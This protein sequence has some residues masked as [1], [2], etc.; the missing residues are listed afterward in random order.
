MSALHVLYIEAGSGSG[1]SSASL[2]R[3]AKV[4]QHHGVTPTVAVR[5]TGPNVEKLRELGVSIF[6]IP[7]FFGR[8]KLFIIP[9]LFAEILFLTALC[10]K[11]KVEI[12]H[13][14]TGV[15]SGLS[16][17]AAAKCLGIPLVSH[18]RGNETMFM[19]NLSRWASRW[20][21]EYLCVSNAVRNVYRLDS[22]KGSRS[23]KTLYDGIDLREFEMNPSVRSDERQKLAL[24]EG[25]CAV[26][27]IA[28]FVE[29]KGHD[30]FL[31]AAQKVL[32][33]EKNV[34]FFL[35]GANGKGAY[36]ERI[37]NL[38][39]TLSLGGK[40]R[41]IPWQSDVK[42]VMAAMD[43]V[44]LPSLGEGLGLAIAEAMALGKAVI[45]TEVGGIPEL[46]RNGQDGILIPPSDPSALAEAMKEL[47][48]NHE[49]RKKMSESGRERILR[50]FSMA[51]V[52]GEALETYERLRL[53]AKGKLLAQVKRRL[54]RTLLERAADVAW[55]GTRAVPWRL[56]RE[57]AFSI[58]MYHRV[59][60]EEVP[61]FT[62]ISVT[63]FERQLAFLKRHFTVLPLGEVV[64]TLSRGKR[65]PRRTVSL[66]FDDGIRN[67]FSVA[68]PALSAMKLPATVFLTTGA[69]D[70]QRPLWT[71]CVTSLVSR[72][73]GETLTLGGNG[74]ERRF[75]TKTVWEKITT[76][77]AL[78]EWL[79]RL[80]DPERN[81]LVEKLAQMTPTFF[82]QDGARMMTWEEAKVM[83]QAGISF[84][85]HTISHPILSKMSNGMLEKEIVGSKERIEAMTGQRVTLFAYPNGEAGDFD[86]RAIGALKAN[87]FTAACTTLYG[88][89][90]DFQEPFILKR[91]PA[92]EEPFSTLACRLLGY[93]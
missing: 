85:A 61:Y 7:K 9:R 32:E 42:P 52:A 44:V 81:T 34:S 22:L 86:E 55:S 29:G 4:L 3:L 17:A 43:L 58:L 21:D 27:M 38:A 10:L 71:D 70:D 59:L 39:E 53:R 16:G 78:K 1:G 57:N 6:T 33:R 26:G 74:I 23:V 84:G 83:S 19:G 50:H 68:F 88:V 67:T 87:G 28:R 65:V 11:E 72:F 54:R 62:G 24:P 18:A 36:E 15:A 47:I 91:V 2:Y 64:D 80:P 14:N 93:R 13:L 20:V 56:G 90:R 63:H 92:Y 41:F 12:V 49:K 69:M 60:K 25:E 66:T 75:P 76:L 45:A 51:R 82:H 89:N 73:E 30:Q 40:I 5:K 79:K 46:V 37:R 35:V 31:N 48:T 8:G 77:K